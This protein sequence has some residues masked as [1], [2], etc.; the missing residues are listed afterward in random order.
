MRQRVISNV[1]YSGLDMAVISVVGY[2]FYI[3]MAKLLSPAEY[4][5]VILILA[6]WF[7]LAPLSVLGLSEGLSSLI[8]R[9][10]V[11]SPMAARSTAVRGLKYGL[12]VLAVMCSLLLVIRVVAPALLPNG[13]LL[14][15]LLAS[16]S[17][18][19]LGRGLLQGFQNFRLLLK[20]DAVAQVLRL[21]LPILLV[22]GGFSVAGAIGGWIAAYVVA[23]ILLIWKVRGLWPAAGGGEPRAEI[24]RFGAT[25]GVAATSYW[26]LL[27]LGAMA[28]GSVG[29]LQ[30]VAFY[31]AAQVAAQM[32]LFFA[33]AVAPAIL[34]SL[35]SLYSK[36]EVQNANLL[37]SIAVKWTAWLSTG[38]AVVL[39]GFAPE[40]ISLLYKAE[41]LAAISIFPAMLIGAVMF[42]LSTLGLVAVYAAGKT[43]ARVWLLLLAAAVETAVLA[44][45][46]ITV[47]GVATAFL[48]GQI[49]LLLAVMAYLRRRFTWKPGI[50]MLVVVVAAVAA[51]YVTLLP[52]PAAVRLFL[53]SA[54]YL[55][56]GLLMIDRNDAVLA[57]ALKHGGLL[58]LPGRLL[59]ALVR[60]VARDV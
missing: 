39:L 41:Y 43:S 46:G 14:T 25:A 37:L 49:V 45:V 42:G 51:Y 57:D 17:A 23:F 26:F 44:A 59:S 1:V 19:L 24:L 7:V 40:V 9:A 30:L 56:L 20:I 35:S 36:G 22:I 48:V 5:L 38:L 10:L 28:L 29:N 4:G 21:V 11:K 34:P 52:L 55:L 16:G 8:P 53:S 12:S 15:A 33:S 54:T 27:Q 32:I 18:L 3:I 13:F 58:G 2:L 60:R 31:G 47:D 50:N 6:Y